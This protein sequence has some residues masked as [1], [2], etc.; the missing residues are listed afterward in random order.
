MPSVN[1]ILEALLVVEDMERSARF[2]QKLFG[3]ERLAED[4]DRLLALSVAGRQVL[5]L[6]KKGSPKPMVGEPCR[7]GRKVPCTWRFRSPRRSWKPGPNGWRKTV[8]GLRCGS[9][10][11]G[12]VRVCTSTI[13]I[14][15]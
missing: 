2:Y 12:E 1:G 9:L 4:P 11:R 10:G 3:F 14:V 7:R 8:S 5:L 13:R 6:A 15:I